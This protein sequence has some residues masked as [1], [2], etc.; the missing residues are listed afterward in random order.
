MSTQQGSMKF[1]AQQARPETKHQER[2]RM[3]GF[4]PKYLS[5]VVKRAVMKYARSE[6]YTV[7]SKTKDGKVVE[8]IAPEHL[9]KANDMYDRL[10][11]VVKLN[12]FQLFETQWRPNQPHIVTEEEL[13]YA[14][15]RVALFIKNFPEVKDALD[16][17]YLI[18]SPARRT[19]VVFPHYALLAHIFME[20]T[21]LKYY[22]FSINA[23]N[24]NVKSVTIHFYV[25]G[26]EQS[27]DFTVFVSDLALTGKVRDK[28]PNVSPPNLTVMLC[29][30]AL[31]Q[32]L[33]LYFPHVV[34]KMAI[35]ID[36]FTT[37][38][39]YFTNTNIG[40]S[41][42]RD[43]VFIPPKTNP[44]ST[45][46][47]E[48]EKSKSNNANLIRELFLN[49]SSRYNDD[50]E[51]MKFLGNHIK[52]MFNISQVKLS[53][54]SIPLE[55]QNAIIDFLSDDANIQAVYDMYLEYKTG[56]TNPEI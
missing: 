6:G 49:I 30:Q 7:K 41:D 38:E 17:I 16:K 36:N 50:V 51:F 8:T 20:R 14:L 37:E 3:T 4:S 45:I 23:E 19:I 26:I 33:V 15:Y 28:Y 40:I 55:I 22:R 1:S 24:G 21:N 11:T 56:S 2:D 47:Q 13:V 29:K 46:V 43:M 5:N 42:N 32:G 12:E 34:T 44:T 31:R 52:E 27:L 39:D 18:P 54:P 10:Y 53:D 35:S 48:K 9:D 25:D